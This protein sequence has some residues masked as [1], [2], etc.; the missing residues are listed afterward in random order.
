MKRFVSQRGARRP[1]Q[2][3]TGFAAANVARRCWAR[4]SSAGILEEMASS[5][6]TDV[7]VGLVVI[8]GLIV[9]GLVGD[10]SSCPK[11]VSRLEPL[12]GLIFTAPGAPSAWS[13]D[14]PLLTVLFPFIVAVPVSKEVIVLL[15]D[16]SLPISGQ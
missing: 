12:F 4:L 2:K 7:T 1:R 3:D 13:P 5:R 9:V 8:V 14:Q 6:A 10:S 11:L 15:K 16:D